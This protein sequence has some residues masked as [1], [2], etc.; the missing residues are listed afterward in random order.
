MSRTAVYTITVDGQDVTSNFHPLLISLAVDLYDGGRADTVEIELDD[1]GGQIAL[2]RVGASLTVSLGWS[3]TGAATIFDGFTDEPKSHAKRHRPG[4]AHEGSGDI[5][6]ITSA[7]SRSRGR[8]LTLAGKSADMGGKVK[9]PQQGHMDDA[10]LGDAARTWGAA[11]GLD[12]VLSGDL[13]SIKRP[14]W[15]IGNESFMA[16]AVRVA[17]ENGATFKIAGTHASF[18]PL[19]GGASV[20]GAALEGVTATWGENL[21]DWS[22]TP[23]QS[24]P[25]F[26]SFAVR[27]YDPV[28]AEW[29]VEKVDG[30]QSAAAAAGPAPS[31]PPTQSTPGPQ[32]PG[33]SSSPRPS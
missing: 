27:H 3:D 15:S 18:T 14:Y 16:W 2:P 17:R 19:A 24:R 5:G 33:S 30:P 9:E 20:S 32:S 25:A 21:I 28:E 1:T 7:G 12:V 8:V 22:I 23:V 26:S 13:A 4:G 6:Q 11:A 10:T 29:K 31:L